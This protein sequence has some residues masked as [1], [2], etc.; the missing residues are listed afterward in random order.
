MQQ[1][2]LSKLGIIKIPNKLRT[3]EM[4]LNKIKVIYAM[5]IVNIIFDGEMLKD[6]P[7]RSTRTQHIGPP[8]PTS[9]QIAME[10]LTQF[11]KKTKNK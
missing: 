9:V 7:L 10:A 4:Y 8:C 3:E 2:F 6:F 1:K 11:E 5:V